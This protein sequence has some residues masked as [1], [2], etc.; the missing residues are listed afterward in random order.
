[1][2]TGDCMLNSSIWP[3]QNLHQ[4]FNAYILTRFSNNVAS[5]Q[6]AFQLV[7]NIRGGCRALQTLAGS[8]Q[9]LPKIYKYTNTHIYKF[10]NKQILHKY[11]NFRKGCGAVL[12]EHFKRWPD[13]NKYF[14]KYCHKYTNVQIHKYTNTQIHKY[15]NITISEGDAEHFKRWPD[16]NKYCQFRKNFSSC[17]VISINLYLGDGE[18]KT[19]TEFFKENP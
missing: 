7:R 3:L 10:T 13:H 19:N 5:I 16:Q 12:R 8:Q 9:I 15:T 18:G 4:T 6:I 11:C 2:F 17:Q 14:Y 1:M